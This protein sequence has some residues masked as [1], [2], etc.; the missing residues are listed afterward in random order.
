MAIVRQKTIVKLRKKAVCTSHSRS[1]GGMRGPVSTIDEQV[2]R[3]GSSH[4]LTPSETVIAALVGCTNVK[5]KK[6]A[7]KVGPDIGQFGIDAGCDFDRWGVTLAEKIEVPFKAIKLS[8]AA[9]GPAKQVEL[10]LVA[11]ETEEFCPLSKL[12]MAG[13]TKL[14]VIWRKD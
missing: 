12:F 8:V 6:C 4:G 14:E 9:S 10:D 1:D 5:A 7:T 13:G 11:V 3:D 2:E